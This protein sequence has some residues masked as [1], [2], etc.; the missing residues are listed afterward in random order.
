MLIVD[1]NKFG[2]V[3]E[4]YRDLRF[5]NSPTDNISLKYAGT[6]GTIVPHVNM[7]NAYAYVAITDAD[8]ANNIPATWKEIALT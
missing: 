3:D 2:N 5:I 4:Q 6:V 8:V 7:T 1:G